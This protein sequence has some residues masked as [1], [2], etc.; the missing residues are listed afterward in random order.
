M[1]RS[2]AKRVCISERSAI[3]E[4]R[5]KLN[6]IKTPRHGVLH[7][8]LDFRLKNAS[9]DGTA[10]SKILRQMLRHLVRFALR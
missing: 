7:D 2:I 4:Q 10:E 8:F 1:V 5:N 6:I 9:G 3:N